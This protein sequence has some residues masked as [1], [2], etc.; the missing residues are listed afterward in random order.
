MHYKV[1]F[2]LPIPTPKTLNP[3]SKIAI[4]APILCS[5]GTPPK[6]LTLMQRSEV[7]T[8]FG[9]VGVLGLGVL[10]VGLEGF[11]VESLRIIVDFLG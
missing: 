5:A 3:S 6:P 4:H 9:V 8:G 10:G 11:R 2:A 1:S 7:R